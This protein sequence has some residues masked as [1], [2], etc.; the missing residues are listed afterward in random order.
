MLVG[1]VV[2]L[3]YLFCLCIVYLYDLH[4]SHACLSCIYSTGLTRGTFMVLSP[5][6]PCA[7]FAPTDWD[8][9]GV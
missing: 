3:F 6:H 7:R 8:S 9:V 5:T 1:C 2:C 4:Y